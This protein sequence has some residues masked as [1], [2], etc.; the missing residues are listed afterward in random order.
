M[1]LRPRIEYLNDAIPERWWEWRLHP[2]QSLFA[3][4]Y[5]LLNAILAIAAAIGFVR[6]KVPLPAMLLAYVALRCVVLLDMPNAEPRYT[7]EAFPIVIV[8]AAAAFLSSQRSYGK[9]REGVPCSA[10]F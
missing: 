4:A 2:G 8:A 9:T 10:F 7:L 6:R 1:W 3:A 5:G